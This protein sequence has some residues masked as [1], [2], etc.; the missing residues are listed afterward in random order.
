MAAEP[1]YDALPGG[2][3][4]VAGLADLRAGRLD[5]PAALLVRAAGT[6]LRAS[7][8]PVPAGTESVDATSALHHAL[9]PEHGDD[10][11]G[12]YLALVRQLESFVEPEDEGLLRRIPG[13]KEAV[14]VNMIGNA[15]ARGVVHRDRVFAVP[16]PRDRSRC[17]PSPRG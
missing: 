7:G 17:V 1:A 10:A 15:R 16:L 3:L 4:V 11:Q 2:D 6:R 14:P 5:T 13:A 12:R 8:V 9:Q